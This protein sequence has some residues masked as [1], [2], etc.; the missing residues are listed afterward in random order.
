MKTF[1]R[2]VLFLALVG[3]LVVII[4]CAADAVQATA[5]AVRF[6]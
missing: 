3:I 6:A 4:A 1:S 5:D 2:I